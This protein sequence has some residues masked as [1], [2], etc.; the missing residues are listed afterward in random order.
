MT[1]DRRK[2]MSFMAMGAAGVMGMPLI[3]KAEPAEK[4]KM[5]VFNAIKTRRSVRAYT[6]KD[7]SEEDVRKILEAAMLAP[8]AANEQ[9]WEFVVIRDKSILDKVGDI[10]KYASYAKKAPVAILACLN[11]NKEKIKGMGIIDVSMSAQNLMLAARG[12]GIGSVFTGIYPEKDR[13]AK[14][15]KLCDL[16]AGVMPIGLI[17]LGYPEIPGEHIV[18]RFNAGAVHTN[19]WNGAP[20]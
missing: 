4:E 7:I 16:P 13:I 20:R 11:E 2:F 15:S 9:P 3:A 1:R 19:K 10:N 17:V 14:F 6:E 5:D 8:S 18:D 12:L